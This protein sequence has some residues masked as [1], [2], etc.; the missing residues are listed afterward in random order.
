L[1]RSRKSIRTTSRI[2][3]EFYLPER[4]ERLRYQVVRDWIIRELTYLRGGTTRIEGAKG[5][6]RSENGGLI[7]DVVTLIWCDFAL[8]W[9]IPKD[10][11][12]A[13]DY[14]TRLRLFMREMLH[15]EEEI[16]IVLLPVL[17]LG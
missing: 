10:R 11:R 1:R 8:D 7:P 17:H 15:E 5:T 6:Y 9:Q 13:L 3:I 4:P 12:Q 2:R 16:L 14:I